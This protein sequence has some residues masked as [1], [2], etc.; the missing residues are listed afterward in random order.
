MVVRD[1]ATVTATQCE[2][3]ENGGGHGVFCDGGDGANT[4][5]RLNDCQMHHNGSDGLLAYNYAVVDLHGT[6]TDIHSNKLH[7]INAF[8]RAKV[9]IHLPSQ[10]NTSPDNVGEDR[11][12]KNGTQYIT[13]TQ[14]NVYAG[15][16]ANINAD[17]TFT[18][19]PVVTVDEE[20]EDANNPWD[21]LRVVRTHK[22]FDKKDHIM[23]ASMFKRSKDTGSIIYF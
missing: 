6:K 9:N 2:F 17:G 18:H 16:I 1:G 13:R 5:A 4:K 7:G 15:S 19:V 14:Y 21:N 12:Q 23:R 3:V 22:Y 10:H 8:D 11:R 20:D